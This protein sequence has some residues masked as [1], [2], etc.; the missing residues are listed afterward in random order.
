MMRKKEQPYARRHILGIIADKVMGQQVDFVSPVEESGC[1]GK[2]NA[3][4]SSPPPP[5]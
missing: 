5:Q 3:L 4:Y 2:G 1:K